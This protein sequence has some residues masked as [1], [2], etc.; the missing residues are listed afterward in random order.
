MKGTDG[1]FIRT[2]GKWS[3]ENWD[4]GYI[5]SDGRFRVYAPDHPRAYS[6]GY[7][8]RSILSY[9]DY[10][11]ENVKQGYNVHHVDGN[12]L[13]DDPKNLVK[14]KHG[15]HTRLHSFKPDSRVKQV[16]KTCRSEFEITRGR[17]ADKDCRRGQYCSPSC[18]YKS[19]RGRRRWT[20]IGCYLCGKEILVAMWKVRTDGHNF[21]SKSCS[22]KNRWKTCRA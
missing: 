4:L 3:K 15:E 14:L 2:I 21:C 1:R 11:G 5:D 19:R 17:L 18:Y 9:E 16:C 8:F 20:K 12:R 6:S 13:N 7:I 22:A 10:Y